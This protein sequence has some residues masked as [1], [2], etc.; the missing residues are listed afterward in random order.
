[1][2]QLEHVFQQHQRRPRE[3]RRRCHDRQRY[4]RRWLRRDAGYE[5]IVLDDTWSLRERDAQGNLVADPAKFPSGMKAL[6][7]YVHARGFKL[8]IYSCAGSKTCAGYPGSQGHEYQDALMGHRL[9][10]IRLV[11]HR[12]P[13]RSRGLHHHA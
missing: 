1:M 10:E 5:Y 9:P 12:N 8:G 11:L 4:A 6:A 7:D 3:G 13:R 2:E